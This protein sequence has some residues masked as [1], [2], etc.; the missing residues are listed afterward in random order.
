MGKSQLLNRKIGCQEM[1]STTN[2]QDL[3]VSIQQ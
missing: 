2:Q 1:L 3:Q